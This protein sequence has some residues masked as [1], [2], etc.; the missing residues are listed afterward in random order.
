MAQRA[1]GRSLI[2]GPIDAAVGAAIGFGEMIAGIPVHS[3]ELHQTLRLYAQ[4]T[5]EGSQFPLA[6]SRPNTASLAEG[7]SQLT[8]SYVQSRYS[9]AQ[10]YSNGRISNSAMVQ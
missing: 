3:P 5:A 4:G 8:L 9:S 7:G 6:A 10:D 2:G 1:A